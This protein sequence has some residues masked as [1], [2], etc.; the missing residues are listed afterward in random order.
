MQFS[1]FGKSG[2]KE[3]LL[4]L[5]LP[6]PLPRN[7]QYI[8][9]QKREDFLFIDKNLYIIFSNEVSGPFAT[10]TAGTLSGSQRLKR[11]GALYL[12]A[13]PAVRL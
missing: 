9:K 11:A 5:L 3:K 13:M 2:R 6:L 1:H 7:E 12:L 4:Y 10:Q 8:Y